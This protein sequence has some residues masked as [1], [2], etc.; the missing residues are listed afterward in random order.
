[1]RD[2]RSCDLSS[3]MGIEPVMVCMQRP[4]SN[5][6]MVVQMMCSSGGNKAKKKK[7]KCSLKQL[8]LFFYNGKFLCK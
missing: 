7:K 3:Q 6:K 4:Y 5:L 1:M 8:K 2:A